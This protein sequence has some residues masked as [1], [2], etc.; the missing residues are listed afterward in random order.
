M[1]LRWLPAAFGSFPGGALLYLGARTI[2]CRWSLMNSPTNRSLEPFVYTF[3]VS[4]KF[5]PASRH[6]SQRLRASPFAA[7]Q[8]HSSPNVIVP[9]AASDTRRPLLPNS[10]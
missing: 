7:P 4:M 1:L 6:G 8:P 9:N 2:L 10:L 3:A 5:P